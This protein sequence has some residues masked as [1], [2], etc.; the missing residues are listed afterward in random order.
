[1]PGRQ[2]H[3]SLHSG[4]VIRHTPYAC[5]VIAPELGGFFYKPGRPGKGQESLKRW[6]KILPT[7]NDQIVALAVQGYEIHPALTRYGSDAKTRVGFPIADSQGE[8]GFT[9]HW[10]V[11]KI[12]GGRI[13]VLLLQEM[14]EQETTA[15]AFLAC[16]QTYSTVLHVRQI[17]HVVGV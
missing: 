9:P 3:N 5:D 15:G 10:R 17:A 4:T 8:F 16:D 7:A 12:E 1:M 11:N 13:E 2:G 14:L 6:L